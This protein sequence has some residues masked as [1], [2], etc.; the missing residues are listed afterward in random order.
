M[1]RS[2]AT[3]HAGAS[4]AFVAS[5]RVNFDTPPLKV[6]CMAT[7]VAIQRLVESAELAKGR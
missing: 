4:I 2:C 5:R 6:C 7:K 1:I 3:S